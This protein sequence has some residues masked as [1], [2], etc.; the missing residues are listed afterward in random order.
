[1][2]HV[3][4]HRGVL[5]LVLGILGF[6]ICFPFG[7]AAWV[8]GNKDLGEI[9]AGRM[10]PD[11]RGLTNAGRIIGMV[12]VIL[13]IVVFLGVAVLFAVGAVAGS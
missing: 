6:A 8:M 3:K 4:A 7:I 1:M 2:A 10:D 12:C 11:G 13:N 9:D 5:I